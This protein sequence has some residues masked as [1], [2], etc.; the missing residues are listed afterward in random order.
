MKLPSQKKILREDLKGAPEYVNGIIDPVNTFMEKTYQALNKNITLTDNIASFVKEI[1]YK[2]TST[3]PTG[4]P[5]IT[6]KNEIRTRPIGVLPMQAYDKATYVPAPGPL[7][8]PWVIDDAGDIM[9]YT[10]TGLE[11][12]KTYLIRLVVF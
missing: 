10:I 8:I 9:V 1:T 6:F 7:Y 5:T 11:A 12:D 4:Q 3:Y 2:T